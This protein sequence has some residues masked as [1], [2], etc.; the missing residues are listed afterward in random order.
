VAPLD[1]SSWLREFSG[2]VKLR[3]F[4]AA[5]AQNVAECVTARWLARADAGGR[6]ER[7]GAK[8]D[9]R[10][11]EASRRLLRDGGRWWRNRCSHG[12]CVRKKMVARFVVQWRRDD[13]LAVV[14]GNGGANGGPARLA[15]AA[16]V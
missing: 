16:A 4:M 3:R 11:G 9:C 5:A 1:G 8:L 10:C 2:G 14:V 7:R 12:C 15:A 13:V 6:R